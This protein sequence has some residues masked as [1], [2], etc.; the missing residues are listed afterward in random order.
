MSEYDLAYTG[1]YADFHHV[2]TNS[3]PLD[4]ILRIWYLLDKIF[5]V[6]VLLG[7]A[8]RASCCS[9]VVSLWRGASISCDWDIMGNGS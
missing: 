6:V 8:L 5:A 7:V 9:S 1:H 4:L 3:A 2:S